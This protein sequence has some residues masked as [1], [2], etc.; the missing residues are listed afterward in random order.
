MSHAAD[1][2]GAGPPPGDASTTGPKPIGVPEGYAAPVTRQVDR[3][4]RVGP[5]NANPYGTRPQR[6]ITAGMP[7]R[8]FD[9]D[10]YLPA[11]LSVEERAQLQRAML[12]AGVYS[13][14]DVV[15]FGLW[16]DVSRKAYRQ[17][18]ELAN[19]SGLS[20]GDALRSWSRAAPAA[21]ETSTR[22]PLVTRVS[23]PADLARLA[24]SVA[25]KVIGRKADPAVVARLAREFQAT[26]A[27]EQTAAYNMAES[28][29]QIVES[30]DPQAFMADRI[31]KE[32]Q[33]EAAAN[34]AAEV[35]AE[36]FKLLDEVNKEIPFL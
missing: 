14:N 9:G 12:A 30:Q 35:G 15:R 7:P 32:Y 6:T 26:Q 10:D 21:E 20:V 33:V 11:T 3:F 24:D 31:R 4:A 17:V 22:A 36:F 2:I 8:Y 34:D 27:A 1:K 29:G 5:F 25:R 23:N 18:L 13:K 16:D 28:G 19:G